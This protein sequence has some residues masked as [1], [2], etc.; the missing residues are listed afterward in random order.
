MIRR[1][2]DA[3]PSV[4]RFVQRRAIQHGARQQHARHAGMALAGA[5]VVDRLHQ[6]GAVGPEGMAWQRAGV[7]EAEIARRV[8]PGHVHQVAAPS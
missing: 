5:Q 7:I 4:G 3:L 1:G 6:A 2:S 8:V